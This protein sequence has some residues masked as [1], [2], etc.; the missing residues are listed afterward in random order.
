[1]GL[2]A[3]ELITVGA[4]VN[5]VAL[6]ALTSFF[7]VVVF[8]QLWWVE[9]TA[10]TVPRRAGLTLLLGLFAS[11]GVALTVVV[12]WLFAAA[13]GPTWPMAGAGAALAVAPALL[14]AAGIVGRRNPR[15][16][17]GHAPRWDAALSSPARLRLVAALAQVDEAE[18]TR[19]RDVI[20]VAESTLSRHLDKLDHVGY[21]RSRKGYLTSGPHTWL[22]LTSPGR[23]ACAQHLA[24]LRN[25][26]DGE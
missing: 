17:R 11:I 1:M 19:V 16:A 4:T 20:D 18:L 12:P 25:I 2:C 15:T 21:L 23:T 5:G 3:V 9:R 7:V 13:E 10:L 6:A 22:S 8:T 14:A 24:A 26:A